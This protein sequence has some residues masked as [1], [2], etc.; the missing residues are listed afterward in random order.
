[1]PFGLTNAP[2]TFMHLMQQTLRQF[3][4]DFVIVFIDDILI[5][6]KTLEDH[7]K[8]LRLVLQV[9]RDKQ[10]YAK[11]SKCDFFQSEISFLGHVIN[12]H[13]IK[14]ESTKVNAVSS[15]PVP[16]NAHE[17]RSFLGLAGYYRR[18]VKD[19][20][21][22]ASHL[23]AL[24]HTNTNYE[25]TAE[26]D[27]AFNKLKSAV[28]TAPILI[29]PN[30]HLPYTVVTDEWLRRRCCTVPRPW[31]WIAAMCIPFTQDE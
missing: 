9:L 1:M 13:G 16:K 10:L 14:M 31:Q 19:F 15:W 6:S 4:D 30:P 12:Q 5:Y 2:A 3:L 27:D 7:Y 21:M 20:S 8:H 25:W 24:L 17:L 11:L 23:T 29:I 28:S 26:Q 18:F 22:I